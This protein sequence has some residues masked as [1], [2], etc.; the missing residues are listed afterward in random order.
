MP[1][2]VKKTKISN[3]KAE[4][5][6]VKTVVNVRVG[7]QYSKRKTV[8]NRYAG[9]GGGRRGGG[10]GGGGGDGGLAIFNRPPVVA[11]QNLS[12]PPSSNVANEYNELLRT[13]AEERRARMAAAPPLA[14]NS[15]PLTT[16]QQRNE[17]LSRRPPPAP[18]API[19]QAYAVAAEATVKKD[20]YDDPTT[21]ENMF[22]GSS[23]LG[24]NISPR[25]PVSNF[26]YN[27]VDAYDDENDYEQ[28][29]LEES[30]A[31]AQSPEQLQEIQKKAQTK[32]QAVSKAYEDYI[33]YLRDANERYAINEPPKSRRFFNSQ[34]KIKEEIRR[35]QEITMRASAQPRKKGSA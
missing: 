31:N 10:G 28:E 4:A 18:F 16:N 34:K 26:D 25:L 21:N 13:L 8:K 6:A 2:K 32:Y 35:V 30:V 14:P 12:P 1:K 22:N 11:T 29:A 19:V 5:S 23:R 20:L 3:V 17:L 33:N 9:G 27:D 24:I 15:A 7:D